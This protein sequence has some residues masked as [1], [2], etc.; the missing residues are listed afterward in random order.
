MCHF[1]QARPPEPSLKPKSDRLLE[2]VEESEVAR[3]VP[4]EEEDDA[5]DGKGEADADI[6]AEA[7]T[8]RFGGVDGG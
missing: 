6:A 3:E 2:G 1:C 5:V 4:E 7:E 8:R